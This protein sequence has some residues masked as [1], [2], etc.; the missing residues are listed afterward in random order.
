MAVP[1]AG[2]APGG[3]P[4]R[5]AGG[6]MPDDHAVGAHRRQGERGVAQRLALGHRR[7]RRADVDGV[8]AHPL[9]GDLERD[10]G[11]GG[12]LVE[13]RDHGAAAQRG[14]LAHLPAQQRLLEPVGGVQ[15]A[16]GRGGVQ[17]GD[18]QQVLHADSPALAAVGPAQPHPVLAV[19][20][21]R[22][23]PG[24]ARPG[25]SARSCPRSRP[26]SAARG[27]PRST[28]TASCTARG[29]PCSASA[30]SAAR[31]VR[32]DISTSSTSTTSASSRPPSGTAVSSSARAGRRR[33]SSR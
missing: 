18:R 8:G 13:H 9:A 15:Q 25:R 10:P 19:D 21:A 23:A 22:A 12:V 30:S 7:A 32:P 5:R 27:G 6:R 24:S 3:Q 28:S 29:R 4:V 2:R 17:V 1:V 31:T 16:G 33:R 26:G 11:A 20:L 14:Q